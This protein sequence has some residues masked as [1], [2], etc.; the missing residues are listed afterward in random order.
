MLPFFNKFGS[1]FFDDQSCTWFLGLFKYTF[2]CSEI[3]TSW[4]E[5]VFFV[6][7]INWA[8]IDEV[9]VSIMR[10]DSLNSYKV[11]TFKETTNP[12]TSWLLVERWISSDLTIVCYKKVCMLWG[13]G[14]SVCLDSAPTDC[15]LR[16]INWSVILV[17]LLAKVTSLPDTKDELLEVERWLFRSQQEIISKYLRCLFCPLLSP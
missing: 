2:S 7:F 10:C 8:H 5:M 13:A 1:K 4:C 9:Q 17:F 6:F 16:P 14:V 12:T 11:I 3:G 15:Y